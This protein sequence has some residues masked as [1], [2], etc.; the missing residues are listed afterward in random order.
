MPDRSMFK[1]CFLTGLEGD[2]DLTRDG[3][4]TGS[5]LGMYLSDKV[6]NYTRSQQ[7]PQYGKINNP[8]LDR[9]D[10]IF[11]PRKTK[12]KLEDENG[13]QEQELALRHELEKMR[14][15]MEASRREREQT[16]KLLADVQSQLE[17]KTQAE[18]RIRALQREKQALEEK[19]SQLNRQHSTMRQSSEQERREL[20]QRLTSTDQ[21]L[22]TESAKRQA[23]ESELGRLRAETARSEADLAAARPGSSPDGRT[24]EA[25]SQPAGRPALTGAPQVNP[26]TADPGSGTTAAGPEENQQLASLGPSRQPGMQDAAILRIQCNVPAADVY[27]GREEKKFGFITYSAWTHRGNTPYSTSDL[28]PGTHEIRVHADGYTEYVKKVTLLPGQTLDMDV[29]IF[30]EHDVGGGGG[31]GG[32]GNPG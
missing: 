3:F 25:L 21:A 19:V 30:Q 5:E 28:E 24:A 22:G 7:H 15:E 10:F 18:E 13:Q 14:R 27:I 11:V 2:A 26:G 32:G 29:R 8:D 16:Q 23:A 12:L 31:G 6:V 9:G 4:V 1:R 20:E 17:E